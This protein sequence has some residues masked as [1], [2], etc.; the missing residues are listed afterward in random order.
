MQKKNC[1]KKLKIQMVPKCKINSE[2]IFTIIYRFVLILQWCRYQKFGPF[3]SPLANFHPQGSK[4]QNM[5][6]ST[7]FLQN[8]TFWK[9][10]GLGALKSFPGWALSAVCLQSAE[11]VIKPCQHSMKIVE[12]YFHTFFTKISWK[13]RFYLIIN[14]L[15]NWFHEIFFNESKFLFFPHCG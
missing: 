1:L 10:F 13:Q 8:T 5:Q 15:I 2:N 4:I 6:K 12:I 14:L 11:N 3:G 7:I 9:L